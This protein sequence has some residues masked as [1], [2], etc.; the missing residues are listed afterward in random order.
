VR[1]RQDEFPEGRWLPSKQTGA[2]KDLSDAQ[3]ATAS[4][5]LAVALNTRS[6][7]LPKLPV[8]FKA[9]SKRKSDV[10]RVA[11]HGW[12]EPQGVS[13]PPLQLTV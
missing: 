9:A 3:H 13:A 10:I 4:P 6:L 5:A 2:G 12:P 8:S 11:F 7:F 1:G